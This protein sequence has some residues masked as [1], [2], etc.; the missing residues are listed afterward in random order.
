LKNLLKAIGKQ[1]N[2]IM[3][4]ITID[5]I[6]EKVSEYVKDKGINLAKMARDTEIPYMAL[7]D[8]LA[9]FFPPL[10][11][12]LLYYKK[13]NFLTTVVYTWATPY[14]NK[15]EFRLI[16]MVLQCWRSPFMGLCRFL[17]C[18]ASEG[19]LRQVL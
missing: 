12:F 17:S 18:F 5:A 4:L 6:T 19:S 7:Y 10:D 13:I 15:K 3:L 14:Y 8:S 1:K 16:L 11:L 9:W 2:G